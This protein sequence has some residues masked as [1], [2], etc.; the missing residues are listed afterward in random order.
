MRDLPVS[1]LNAPDIKLG[2]YLE[3]TDVDSVTY[4]HSQNEIS[5]IG[6]ISWQIPFDGGLAKPANYDITLN[7]GCLDTVKDLRTKYLRAEVRLTMVVGS[8]GNTVQLHSGRV[9]ATNIGGDDPFSLRLMVLDKL[10]DDN[11]TLPTETLLDSY[12]N[13]HL[14]DLTLGHPIYYG[15]HH[16][17]IYHAAVSCDLGILLAPR[18]ISSANHVNSV[19]FNDRLDLGSDIILNHNI[20]MNM[21]WDA[22]TDVLSNSQPFEVMDAGAGETRFWEFT[23]YASTFSNVS[24]SGGTNNAGQV[25]VQ[26]HGFL[27]YSPPNQG[28]YSGSDAWQA[29]GTINKLIKAPINFLTEVN[30]QGITSVQFF[31]DNF[32]Y[33]L[34]YLTADSGAGVFQDSLTTVNCRIASGTFDVSSHKASPGIGENRRMTFT[35][36]LH[37]GGAVVRGPTFTVSL[38][39]KASLKSEGY[40][41]YSVFSPPVNSSDVAISANPFGIFDDIA[42][43]HLS[44]IY[45]QDQSSQTQADLQAFDVELQMFIAEQFPAVKIIDELGL[46]SGVS[47]WAADSGMLKIKSYQESATA[48][49]SIN[50]TITLCD[51]HPGAFILAEA[52]LGTTVTGQ[53]LYSK[54]RVDYDYDFQSKKYRKS[55]LADK[56]NNNLCN[57][58]F[59]SGITKTLNISTKYIT[60]PD[61]A[62]YALGNLVRKHAQSTDFVTFKGGP[63]LL[64]VELADVLKVQHPMLVGSEG[65]FQVVKTKLDIIP[66]TVEVTAAKLVEQG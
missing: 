45:H 49:N 64:N 43:N 58:L 29:V 51:I 32:D 23:P 16:R 15:R 11:P 50:Q 65:L 12:S 60:N 24:D 47:I 40:S 42:T 38:A 8:E 27:E 17:S 3:L 53:E 28:I 56:N 2:A 19:W 10:F 6:K 36:Q 66:G 61:V 20:L 31:A 14:E 26:D 4:V 1:V 13:V 54:I 46:L 18:N 44:L 30:F 39:M 7:V 63:S 57:S 41:R 37:M 33:T 52:P 21:P 62:S 9:R 25:S 22:V 34:L 48:T 35:A 55:K 59:N 5:N